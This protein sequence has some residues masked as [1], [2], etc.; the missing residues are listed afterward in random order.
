MRK[1][2]NDECCAA[3][4]GWMGNVEWESS[5]YSPNRRFLLCEYCGQNEEAMIDQKGCN[6]LPE[7]I[8][9]YESNVI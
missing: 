2:D 7:L 3:C 9:L 8:K 1:L 5:V 4:R 6:D